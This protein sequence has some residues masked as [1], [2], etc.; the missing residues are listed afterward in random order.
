M[1]Q[2]P[3]IRH[4]AALF[5]LILVAF[6]LLRSGNPISAPAQSP[7]ISTEMPARDV[8]EPSGRDARQGIA[9]QPVA[10]GRDARQGVSKDSLTAVSTKISPSQPK[11]S[12]Q[13]TVAVDET[14]RPDQHRVKRGESLT[15]VARAWISR[16]SYM[17]VPELEAALRETNGLKESPRPGDVL[18]IPGFETSPILEHPIARPRDFEVKAIYLT[19]AMAGSDNGIRLV[20]HWREVG[21]NAIV[22]DIKDSDGSVSVPFSNPL[23]GNHHVA[24]H[25]L[26]KFIRFLHQNQLHAIARI[27]LFRDENIAQHHSELAVRS[28]RTGEPWRENGKLVWTDPSNPEVQAYDLALAKHV[29]A[30]GVDEV[31][32]DYVRF[33]AEGD[34]KDAQFAFEKTHPDWKR[35]DVIADFLSRAYKDLHKDGVLLSLDVF[36]VMAWARPVDLSHT[37]QD[38]SQMSHYCDVLSPMIYP[39]HFFGMDGYAQPGDAPEHFISES[40]ERFQAVTKGSDV[41]LRPWLQAFAW[42]TKTYSPAYIEAQVSTAR[43]NGGIGFLFWNARNDYSKP[44]TAMPEM[45]AKPAGYFHVPAAPTPAAAKS[46]AGQ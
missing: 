8:G 18:T 35:S 5:A 42:R 9:T 34:Q 33:P 12:V 28:R 27:A 4:F 44:F 3:V 39:S 32:F 20:R 15:S 10:N 36:G 1:L 38:I 41:V 43:N 30:S 40:M 16:T 6:V 24:I 17:T 45:R 13:P 19:G 26:A 37:G 22:F 31:Q 46:T 11:P 2:H 7:A 14:L 25:N 29:A 23:A 21:G